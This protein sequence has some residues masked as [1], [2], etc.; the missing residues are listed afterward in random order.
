MSA[1]VPVECPHC[2][3]RLKLPD[4]SRL[5]KNVRCPK[6]KEHFAAGP[7]STKQNVDEERPRSSAEFEELEEE[8][9]PAPSPAR[10]AKPKSAASKKA[11]RG[12]F[13]ESREPW[14]PRKDEG[15]HEG[16]SMAVWPLGGLVG[17]GAA[18]SLW[19]AAACLLHHDWSIFAWGV[20][21]GTGGGVGYTASKRGNTSSGVLAAVMAVVFILTFKFLI[22]VITVHQSGALEGPLDDD[23]LIV[24]EAQ[25]IV[26]D[27]QKN[28]RR[29]E[30]PPGKSPNNAQTIDDYPAAV[31]KQAK[32]NWNAQT[33]RVKGMREMADATNAVGRSQIGEE[34]A[35]SFG[36]FGIVFAIFGVAT[37]YHVGRGLN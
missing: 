33:A 13:E 31:A 37:A 12:T 11:R 28:G 6:C 1:P 32:E 20:G 34:F 21:A 10:R 23:A 36:V 25:F 4:A 18:G 8:L 14:R 35:D 9:A 26:I 5:G 29:L 2:G 15:F 7:V 3:A 22:A 27:A 19:L 17:G 24:A 30:W 16:W